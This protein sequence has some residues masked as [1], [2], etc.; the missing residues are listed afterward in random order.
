[1]EITLSVVFL[2]KKLLKF[3]NDKIIILLKIIK[4]LRAITEKAIMP[5]A[6]DFHEEK[7]KKTSFLTTLYP[8]SQYQNKQTQTSN[9]F[10]EKAIMPRAVD[11]YEEKAK[12]TSFLTKEHTCKVCDCVKN[13]VFCRFLP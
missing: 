7:A 12:K 10:I 3:Y 1:M 11:F 9:C 6:V 13:E 2:C 4:T 5:R 8:L